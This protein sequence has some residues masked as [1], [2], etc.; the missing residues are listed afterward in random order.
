MGYITTHA[1]TAAT[2]AAVEA[3]WLSGRVAPQHRSIGTTHTGERWTGYAPDI[4]WELHLP[5]AGLTTPFRDWAS[6]AT[7]LALSAPA[8]CAVYGI[9]ALG[10]RRA[11]A[12][13][14]RGS[15]RFHNHNHLLQHGCEPG[16]LP[17]PRDR[18][19]R[20]GFRCEPAWPKRR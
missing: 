2:A 12:S 11:V 3:S 17:G 19:K 14:Q 15:V 4:S 10:V 13:R 6:C 18:R 5:S 7:A 20:G 1:D 16:E 8:D 9:D